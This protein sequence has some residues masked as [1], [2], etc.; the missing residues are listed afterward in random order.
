MPFT[1]IGKSCPS[2][3]FFNIE[4]MCFNAIHEKKNLAKNFRIYSI[5]LD[6][7]NTVMRVTYMYI[8]KVLNWH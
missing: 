7:K 8:K 6:Q 1:D 3:R 2:S 5:W 4:N